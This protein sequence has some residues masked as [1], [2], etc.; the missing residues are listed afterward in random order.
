MYFSRRVESSLAF[1]VKFERVSNSDRIFSFTSGSF[2][3]KI[4]LKATLIAWICFAFCITS[5]F[6]FEFTRLRLRWTWSPS[7][8]RILQTICLFGTTY[9]RIS[10]IRPAA[11]SEEMIVPSWLFGSSTNVIVFVTFFTLQRIRS[12]SFIGFLRNLFI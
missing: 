7:T 12:F 9:C 11:I 5:F 1:V 2:S 10:L 3:F 4:C 6:S 8:R